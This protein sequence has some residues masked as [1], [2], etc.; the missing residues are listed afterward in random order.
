[1]LCTHSGIV[2]RQTMKL[3][4]KKFGLRKNPNP[5]L[6]QNPHFYYRSR[7]TVSRIS[8]SFVF[9]FMLFLKTIL[10]TP[11]KSFTLPCP[12][13][14]YTV[15]CLSVERLLHLRAP[16]WSDKVNSLRYG[17]LFVRWKSHRDNKICRIVFKQG[18]LLGYILP[19]LVFS[20]FYNFP[21]FFE[22][23]TIYPQNG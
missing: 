3:F 16:R 11:P 12:A 9:A 6:G 5:W 23:T 15:V 10:F 2:T 8:F 17:C 1:M 21:K 13:T 7:L 19:V 18:A 20:T 4:D 22:F 14:V